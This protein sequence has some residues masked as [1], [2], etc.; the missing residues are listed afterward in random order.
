MSLSHSAEH[1]HQRVCTTQWHTHTNARAHTSVSD[2]HTH[3][4]THTHTHTHT[5][6]LFSMMYP[7]TRTPVSSNCACCVLSQFG[8]TPL[9]IANDYGHTEV[10]ERLLKAAGG[11]AKS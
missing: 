5:H 6:T 3:T 2:T 4:R 11:G 10:A 1:T 9:D 7:Y 8:R